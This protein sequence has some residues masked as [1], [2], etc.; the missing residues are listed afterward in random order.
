MKRLLT[1]LLLCLFLIGGCGA[2]GTEAPAPT[3]AVTGPATE[4]E[5]DAPTTAP[6]TA[7][8]ATEA[9]TE[10]NFAHGYNSAP[11]EV[12]TESSSTDAPTNSNAEE[13]TLGYT[14]DQIIEM[15][16]AYTQ[17]GN[18]HKIGGTLRTDELQEANGKQYN[19]RTHTLAPGLY[20]NFSETPE[21]E[22]AFSVMVYGTDSMDKEAARSFGFIAGSLISIFEEERFDEVYDRFDFGYYEDGFSEITYGDNVRFE[23]LTESNAFCF[24]ADPAERYLLFDIF[25]DLD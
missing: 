16:D 7:E 3:E 25:N 13:A 15:L 21:D 4:A 22:N 20:V 19:I 14:T 18:H 9:K 2:S 1:L 6:T 10:W 8:A 23:Y 17:Y 24:F 12:A 11:T 5:T